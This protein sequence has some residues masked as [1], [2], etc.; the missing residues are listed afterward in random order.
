MAL[1]VVLLIGQQHP[2]DI[3]GMIDQETVEEQQFPIEQIATEKLRPEQR[4]LIGAGAPHQ[5]YWT[6]AAGKIG[7]LGGHGRTMTEP[8]PLS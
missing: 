5:F 3:V 8:D 7:V 1:G 6:E 2:L 4:K